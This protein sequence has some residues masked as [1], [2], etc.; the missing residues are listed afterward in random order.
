MEEILHQ[1]KS[2]LSHTLLTEFSTSQVVSRISSIN[3]IIASLHRSIEHDPIEKEKN[4]QNLHFKGSMLV[5]R[6]VD[7]F[8]SSFWFHLK[9]TPNLHSFFGDHEKT[10]REPHQLLDHD[11]ATKGE[12][13]QRHVSKKMLS[14]INIHE[15]TSWMF[16]NY[17]AQEFECVF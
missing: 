17:Y 13:G 15:T 12:V 9:C 4:L 14:I 2:S 11:P 5:F 3:S 10:P 1:L 8:I 7:L 6:G 16:Q